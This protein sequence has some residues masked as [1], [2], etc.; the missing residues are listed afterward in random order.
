MKKTKKMIIPEQNMIDW[1]YDYIE[2]DVKTVTLQGYYKYVIKN[3]KMSPQDFK[4]V[5]EF[6]GKHKDLLNMIKAYAE[7]EIVENCL[8]GINNVNMGQFI[9]KNSHG[10]DDE[11]PDEGNNKSKNLTIT[12]E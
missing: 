8:I 9:L 10:Y 4:Q 12:F 6:M 2:S 1:F 5:K 11:K 3:R 7:G